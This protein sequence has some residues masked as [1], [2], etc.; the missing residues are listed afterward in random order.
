MEERLAIAIE[1][2]RCIGLMLTRDSLVAMTTKALCS[3]TK[4][5]SVRF[6]DFPIDVMYKDRRGVVTNATHTEI[7]SVDEASLC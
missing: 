3:N 7:V 5:Y 6:L 4:S 2:E 1:N